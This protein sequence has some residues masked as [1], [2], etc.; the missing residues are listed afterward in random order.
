MR[1]HQ[2]LRRALPAVLSTGETQPALRQL[3]PWLQQRAQPLSNPSCPSRVR[4]ISY[5][6]ARSKKKDEE[7]LEKLQESFE[8]E[9]LIDRRWTTKATL[10]RTGRE[11]WP[12]DYEITDPQ[13]MVYDNG[14]VEGPLDTKFVLTK[15]QSHESL[16]MVTPYEPADP[17][18]GKPEKFPL[19]KIVEKDAEFKKKREVEA[20]QKA[21]K[22][23][24]KSGKVKQFDLSWTST[25][26]DIANKVK[27]IVESLSKGYSVEVNLSSKKKGKKKD[28]SGIDFGHVLKQAKDGIEA[29]GAKEK[30]KQT[31][32]LGETIKLSY[33]PD[34]KKQKAAQAEGGQ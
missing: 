19:C 20:R 6:A 28:L 5:T 17:K 1:R 12:W 14:T 27:R 9:A 26:H 21:E 3:P 31:G 25:D 33:E 34:P 8:K 32:E 15:I 23:R 24:D 22:A 29:G 18:T 11:R 2:C 4:H 16:R 13:I 30:K 10:E 7:D